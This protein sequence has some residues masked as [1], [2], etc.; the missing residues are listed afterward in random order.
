VRPLRGATVVPQGGT[1]SQRTGAPLQS[2]CSMSAY[3]FRCGER[4][5]ID[6]PALWM[7]KPPPPEVGAGSGLRNIRPLWLLT[8]IICVLLAV[9]GVLLLVRRDSGDPGSQVMN[10]LVPAASALPGYGTASLN[11]IKM[12]PHRDSCDGRP[13][14]QGWTQVVVQA[15][16][17]WS[18]GQSALI[19]YIRPRLAKLGWSAD[20]LP[21]Q[22]SSPSGFGWTKMLTNGTKAELSV[23]PEGGIWE[24]VALGQPI[25]TAASGC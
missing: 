1:R 4:G 21:P 7:E 23:T 2:V 20:D 8:A 12:E 9:G 16:F 25:G 15:R 24:V 5:V 18:Q 3:D 19:A 11:I 10:Q 14:T 13:G 17:G 22:G 6:D